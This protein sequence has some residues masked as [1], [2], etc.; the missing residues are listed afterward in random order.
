MPDPTPPTNTPDNTPP[1]WYSSL[2]AEH[3]GHVQTKGWDKLEPG[4]AALEL[5]KAHRSAELRLG[6]PAEQLLRLPRDTA[7]ADGWKSVWQKLGAPEKPEDYDFS[8]VDFDDES[9]TNTFR[10]MFR[11]TAAKLHLPKQAAE[12]MAKAVFKSIEDYG[13]A[14]QAIADGKTA[15]AREALTQNWGAED[16]PR[17]KAN[18]AIADRAAERLGVTVEVMEALK[19]GM[20]GAGVA[21]LFHKIGVGLGEAKFFSDPGPGGRDVMTRDQAMARKEELLGTGKPGSGD[22]GFIDRYQ[23]GDALARQEI[24]ALNRLIA[25][26][27]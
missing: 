27:E 25:G 7:D 2:D 26:A 1:A 14:Q 6:V 13:T 23:K 15:E 16:S 11:D 8:S 17:F 10:T 3:I 20:G 19:A 4:A 12:E 9:M 21:E 24:A 22:Q 5:V 18:M